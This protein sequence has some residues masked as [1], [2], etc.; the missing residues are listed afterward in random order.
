MTLATIVRPDQRARRTYLLPDLHG[1]P[2]LVHEAPRKPERLNCAGYCQWCGDRD[3][4]SPVCI[5]RDRTSEWAVCPDCHG[6]EISELVA[7]H[8]FSGV[9]QVGALPAQA[10]RPA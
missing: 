8:C 3:C 1:V 7:C 9:V 6:S 5:D 2:Q 4:T 10:T